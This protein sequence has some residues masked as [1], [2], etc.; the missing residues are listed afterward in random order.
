MLLGHLADHAK[1]SVRKIIKREELE[2][3]LRGDV[4]EVMTGLGFCHI[5]CGAN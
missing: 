3:T 1:R 5:M 4:M 2:C